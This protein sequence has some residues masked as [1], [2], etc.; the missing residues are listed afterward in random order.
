MTFTTTSDNV[1]LAWGGHISTSPDWDGDPTAVTIPGSPYHMRVLASSGG[2]GNQDRSLSASA[3]LTADPTITINK[4]L[5]DGVGADA[6]LFNLEIDGATAGGA[7][8]V[9]NGGT[10]GAVTVPAGTYTI[11]ESAGTG[12]NLANYMT[13]ISGACAA[14]GTVTVA[15]DENV[16]C[17]ITNTRL[18]RTLRLAKSLSPTNDPGTFDLRLDTNVFIVDEAINGSFGDTTVNVDVDGSVTVDEISGDVGALANYTSSLSCAGTNVVDP[19]GTTTGDLTIPA[20]AGDITCTFTN[21]LITAGITLIKDVSPNNGDDFGLDIDGPDADDA[22]DPNVADGGSI[23]VPSGVPGVYNLSESDGT[24]ALADYT[25]TLNCTGGG[26]NLTYNE[27]DTSGSITLAADDSVT[28]TFTNTFN[29]AGLTLIKDVSPNNG[30]DFGLDIDGPA[31]DDANDPNVADGESISV[32]S[33]VPGVYNLSESDGTGALADYTTTLNCTGGGSDFTYNEGDTNGSITLATDDDVTCTFTN[34]FNTAGITLIKDVSPNNGDDFGLA[35]DGPAADDASDPNVGDGGSIS[36]LSGAPGVYNLSESDG[37][38]ALADYTTT[39]NCTGGSDFTYNE[40]DTNGSIT[41]AIDDSVTCTFTNTFV[42][43]LPEPPGDG[44][45]TC[46][47][48]AVTPLVRAEGIAELLGDII[49]VCHTIP[50]GA[51]VDPD[52]Y[53]EVNVTASLNVSVTNNRDFNAGF[54]DDTTDAVL[55]INE[56]NCGAPTDRGARMDALGVTDSGFEAGCTPPDSDFQDPQFGVLVT[57]NR[58][59]WTGVQVP[60]PGFGDFPEWTTIRL[61][62]MRGNASELGIPDVGAPAFAQIQATV[63]INGESAITL[64][65]NEANIGLPLLGLI[66]SVDEAASGLQCEDEGDHATLTINE[67]FPTAFKTI[68]TALFTISGSIQV[69][70]GYPAPDSGTTR[71][72]ATAE[73][74]KAGRRS[75]R[76]SC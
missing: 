23:S 51:V 2:G 7:S 35:I 27:G 26:S 31:A 37:T 24:G 60:V 54:Q 18:T 20:G 28:C 44:L 57:N 30:D 71:R 49:I 55:V 41:L 75:R 69:E 50:A 15:A 3:I 65:K 9:G 8:D 47:L 5:V 45:I 36:V 32:L 64:N 68:G 53:I 12:T 4:V 74:P 40:G 43:I 66:S 38:G 22:S 17:T 29:T 16:V 13:V 52:G 46:D 56:N 58:L 72:R 25:T 42:E 14:D 39:L 48:G 11:G 63:T 21:T 67:G 19:G 10:S 70:N 61:T 76:T 73:R 6:G 1:M 59:E 62:S 33:G 34:T